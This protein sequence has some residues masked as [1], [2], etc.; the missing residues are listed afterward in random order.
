MH[1][2]MRHQCLCLLTGTWMVKS[3]RECL[4]CRPVTTMPLLPPRCC[5]R[6]CLSA[7]HTLPRSAPL[8]SSASPR[9]APAWSALAARLARSFLSATLVSKW[10]DNEVGRCLAGRLARAW[11]FVLGGSTALECITQ[12]WV[13]EGNRSAR[14][15]PRLA[16]LGC[17]TDAGQEGLW[18]GSPAWIHGNYPVWACLPSPGAEP[19]VGVGSSL[20]MRC[21][22]RPLKR[23]S[24]THSSALVS[25]R[26]GQGP[27]C[28]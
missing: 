16:A 27:C 8:R 3:A 14:Q 28:S 4:H 24:Y 17:H 10:G 26:S 25:H 15:A 23:H 1:L 18:W 20:E 9:P 19:S 2:C 11:Q 21:M 22:P 13:V 12:A 7:A 5:S 6:T